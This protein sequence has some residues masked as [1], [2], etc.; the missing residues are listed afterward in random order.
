MRP[1]ADAQACSVL[2][3]RPVFQPGGGTSARLLRAEKAGLL[4]AHIKG[5][6]PWLVVLQ[7]SAQVLQEVAV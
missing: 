5:L 7:A 4:N 1:Q 2:T 6:L 3:L